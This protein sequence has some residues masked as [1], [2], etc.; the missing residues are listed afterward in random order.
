[1]TVNIRIT[2]SEQAQMLNKIAEQ[3]PFDIWI[4]GRSGQA[5][6]KSMLGLMLLTIEDDVKLVVDDSIDASELEK[7]IEIFKV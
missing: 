2:T 1:M 7:E 3:Y 4:H 6:A 5:D